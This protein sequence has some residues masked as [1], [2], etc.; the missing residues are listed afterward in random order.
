YIEKKLFTWLSLRMH[1]AARQEEYLAI[2]G[3]ESWRI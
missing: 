1:R 3:A 2:A